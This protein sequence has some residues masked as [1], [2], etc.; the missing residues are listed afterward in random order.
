MSEQNQ[1]EALK[2]EAQDEINILCL[3][4]LIIALVALVG[5]VFE[6]GGLAVLSESMTKRLRVAMLRAMFRQE[7][8]FHDDP[9]NTPGM[10]ARSLE[11]WAFRVG[12]LCQSIG[13]KLG[14]LTSLLLGISIAFAY[15]WQMA[16]MM[17]GVVPVIVAAHSVQLLVKLGASNADNLDDARAAQI[18]NDS[19][20]NART[21]QAL[22]VEKH[23]VQ[24]YAVLVVDSGKRTWASNLIA[25]VGFGIAGGAVFFVLAAGFYYVP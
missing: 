5:S 4:F 15:C 20:M 24:K 23:R 1:V 14:A 22:G 10:L 11:L 17:L 7:I 8:G 9:E 13:A 3:L 18:V 12:T 16:L 19:I 25:G 2:E 21:V 6:H